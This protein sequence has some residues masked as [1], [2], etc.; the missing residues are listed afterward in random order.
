LK[1]VQ[2]GENDSTTMP[3]HTPHPLTPCRSQGQ[4]ASESDVMAAL[5]CCCCC[6]WKK[7]ITLALNSL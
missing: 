7:T 6:R 2:L 3:T 4:V 5:C 1:Q